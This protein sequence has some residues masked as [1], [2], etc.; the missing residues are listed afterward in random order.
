MGAAAPEQRSA[1]PT[2]PTL[3]PTRPAPLHSPRGPSIPTIGGARCYP[4]LCHPPAPAPTSCRVCS[5][6]STTCMHCLHMG[7]SSHCTLGIHTSTRTPRGRLLPVKTSA[8]SIFSESEQAEYN[9]TTKTARFRGRSLRDVQF[10]DAQWQCAS[11][12][13]SLPS[14]AGRQRCARQSLVL[15][16]AT[17]Y[18]RMRPGFPMDQ[19]PRTRVPALCASALLRAREAP[20]TTYRRMRPGFPKDQAP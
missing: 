4:L 8:V 12:R 7:G 20:A 17:A 19:T 13:A 10:S 16:P 18:R 6:S 14:F 2:L 15:C 5:C 11:L 1:S 3:D 9:R